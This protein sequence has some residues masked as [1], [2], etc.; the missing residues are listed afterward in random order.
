M[1][2]RTVQFI[3]DMNIKELEA[4]AATIP[5]KGGTKL[6]PRLRK[7][8]ASLPDNTAIVEVGTW[9]GA[10][11]AQL[12][13][14]V[15]ESKKQISIHCYDNWQATKIEA[16][17]AHDK[18]NGTLEITAGQDTLPVVKRYLEPFSAVPIHFH[19]GNI[20]NAHWAAKQNIGL[21]IDDA[22]KKARTFRH[23]LRT[24]GP[25]WVPGETTLVLMDYWYF[26]KKADSSFRFQHDWMTQR[27]QHFSYVEERIEGGSTAILKYTKAYDFG[28]PT[29]WLRRLLG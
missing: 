6:G 7:I 26:Q 23:M 1:I 14:G 21:Y 13:L 2:Q 8:V 24:F 27:A 22:A 29:N 15:L 16:Q 19:K 11:T 20:I 10:G 9:L 17:K 12:A 18:S 4:Y 5:S 28:Q 3:L 25:Y